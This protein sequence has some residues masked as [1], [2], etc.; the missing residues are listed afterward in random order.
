LLRSLLPATLQS[1]D[2][3][4]FRHTV[5]RIHLDEVSGREARSEQGGAS[6]TKTR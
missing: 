1:T 4:S 6:S 3:A 5:F 2:P